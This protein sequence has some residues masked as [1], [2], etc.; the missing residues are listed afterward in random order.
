LT[1]KFVNRHGAN[2]GRRGAFGNWA[3]PAPTPLAGDRGNVS[4]VVGRARLSS[5]N[6]IADCGLR[7][8]KAIPRLDGVSS[9]RVHCPPCSCPG[10]KTNELP[11]D[12]QGDPFDRTIAATAA[13]L[14]LTL[15]TTDSAIRDARVCEVKYYPFRLSR[16]PT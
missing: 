7:N 4:L 14:H 5:R 9:Y 11:A 6:W 10:V 13:I 12:F 8:G 16:T 15:I 3:N 2:I 1:M